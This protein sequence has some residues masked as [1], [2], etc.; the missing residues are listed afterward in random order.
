M[1]KLKNWQKSLRRTAC[2]KKKAYDTK[3][4]VRVAAARRSKQI[5]QELF[6]Y[7]CPFCRAYHLTRSQQHKRSSDE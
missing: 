5:G 4:E 3:A 2:K 1:R 6:F 7:K